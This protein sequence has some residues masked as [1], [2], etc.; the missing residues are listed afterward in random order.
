[1]ERTEASHPLQSAFR[2]CL[3]SAVSVCLFLY[4]VY[5]MLDQPRAHLEEDAHPQNSV[6]RP[7]QALSRWSYV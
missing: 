6:P 1:M 5:L 3:Q 2:L 7:G 4:L